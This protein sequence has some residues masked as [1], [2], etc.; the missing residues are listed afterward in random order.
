MVEI[1]I[2]ISDKLEKNI[3]ETAERLGV[4]PTDYIKGVILDDLKKRI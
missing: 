1:R 4:K 3:K 2:S